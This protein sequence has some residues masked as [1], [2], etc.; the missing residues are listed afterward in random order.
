MPRIL[1]V[2]GKNFLTKKAAHVIYFKV[3]DFTKF[4][5]SEVKMS[6]SWIAALRGQ[7]FGHRL[8]MPIIPAGGEYDDSFFTYFFR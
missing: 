3:C 5:I 2:P 1:I 4:V 6:P 7:T 8:R